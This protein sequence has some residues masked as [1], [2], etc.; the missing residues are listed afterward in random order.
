MVPKITH[1]LRSL[2]NSRAQE[3]GPR[4]SREGCGPRHRH[5]G[6]GPR[7]RRGHGLFSH[8]PGGFGVRRPLRF[9]GHR[10]GL[11]DEQIGSLA[12]ILDGLKTER[13]QAAVDERRSSSAIADL[14]T[15]DEFDDE[16]AAAVVEARVETAKRL[17]VALTGALK[18][19]HGILGESQRRK[20]ATLIRGGVLS[21]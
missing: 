2:S 11:D 10:L 9:L 1:W 6:H 16:A 17:A 3:C 18:E 5:G 15:V 14:L 8:G 20:L 21:V 19:V 13:A 12:R 7:G 4:G